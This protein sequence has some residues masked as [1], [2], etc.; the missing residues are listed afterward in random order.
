MLR[1]RWKTAD[2]RAERL[3]NGGLWWNLP[4]RQQ[5][6]LKIWLGGVKRCYSLE[7]VVSVLS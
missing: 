7:V 2:D 5:L 4:G 3:K 1:K 6:P